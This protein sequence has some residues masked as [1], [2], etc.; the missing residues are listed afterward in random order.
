MIIGDA[1]GREMMRA[2]DAWAEKH[3]P[4]QLHTMPPRIVPMETLPKSNLRGPLSV[5]QE[6]RDKYNKDKEAEKARIEQE[7]LALEEKERKALM[8][9]EEDQR[10]QNELKFMQM[11][12]K[13]D[14]LRLKLEKLDPRKKKDSNKIAEINA[15]LLSLDRKIQEAKDSGMINEHDLRTGSKLQR[16]WE[17]VKNRTKKIWKKI[18]KFCKK[19]RDVIM[20]IV[21]VVLPVIL[22]KISFLLFSKVIK[23]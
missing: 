12:S 15:R 17:A 19:H 21:R 6:Y 2:A 10:K 8:K 13:R 3:L 1:S 16:F 18:K 11:L 14:R 20:D 9:K 5:S 22:T 23:V 7:R 4:S